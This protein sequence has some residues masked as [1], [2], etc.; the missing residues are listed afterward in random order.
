MKKPSSTKV[1]SMPALR[2]PSFPVSQRF[3]RQLEQL[4]VSS[5]TAKILLQH[6]RV[7]R[8]GERPVA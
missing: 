8:G 5:A 6:M 2:V 7:A 3:Y 4:S 1:I